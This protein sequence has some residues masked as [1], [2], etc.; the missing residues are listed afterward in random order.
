MRV[1]RHACVSH[2]YP[3]KLVSIDEGRRGVVGIKEKVVSLEREGEGA[4]LNE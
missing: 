2:K 1:R 4:E 3:L